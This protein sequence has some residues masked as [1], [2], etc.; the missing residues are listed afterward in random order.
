M[1]LEVVASLYSPSTNILSPRY[2]PSTGIRVP[3]SRSS[4]SNE[5]DT[6]ESR[7]QTSDA[8]MHMLGGVQGSGE[9]PFRLGEG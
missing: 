3:P 7:R 6:N 1:R 5:R 4:Q 8:L 9:N 2:R